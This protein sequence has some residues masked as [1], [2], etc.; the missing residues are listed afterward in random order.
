VASRRKI[1]DQLEADG[2]LAAICHFSDPGFGKLV[3]L[4]GKRVWQVLW[5][6]SGDAEQPRLRRG[7]SVIWGW[8]GLAAESGRQDH[9][10]SKHPQ[11][12]TTRDQ[13]D[14]HWLFAPFITTLALRLWVPY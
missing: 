1:F 10:Q 12:R 14:T 5:S 9:E 11:E 4:E 6:S 7:C 3:R 13:F 8:E 2:L